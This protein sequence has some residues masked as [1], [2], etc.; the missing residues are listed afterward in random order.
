M[1]IVGSGSSLFANKSCPYLSWNVMF[2]PHTDFE[3]LKTSKSSFM[4]R[5]YP[6]VIVITKS[7]NNQCWPTR[8]VDLKTQT[9]VIQTIWAGFVV[10]QSISIKVQKTDSVCL[11][12]SSACHHLVQPQNRMS[13]DWWSLI[14]NYILVLFL[15]HVTDRTNPRQWKVWGLALHRLVTGFRVKQPQ[16]QIT[17]ESVFFRQNCQVWKMIM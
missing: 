9:S 4:W 7:L 1:S 13:L 6:D 3:V 12:S 2:D 14:R 8:Y 15:V 10:P 11:M 16:T 5:I 17:D